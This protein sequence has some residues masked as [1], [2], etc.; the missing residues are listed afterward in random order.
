MT[1]SNSWVQSVGRQRAVSAGALQ[2]DRLQGVLAVEASGEGT[3]VHRA[4]ARG[5]AL[6]IV[7]ADGEVLTVAAADGS[8]LGF[9]LTEGAFTATTAP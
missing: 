3:R 4:P 1:Y 5:G 9:D 6:R 8:G 7:G 2:S